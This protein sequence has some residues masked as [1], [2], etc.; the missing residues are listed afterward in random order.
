MLADINQNQY[1]DERNLAVAEGLGKGLASISKDQRMLDM[2]YDIARGTDPTGAFNR[3]EIM[4]KL[5]DL[6]N[7]P[8]SPMYKKSEQEL[9]KIASDLGYNVVKVV[10]DDKKEK[11][12]GGFK[13]VSG[14]K[15]TSRL[16]QLATNKNTG[17]KKSI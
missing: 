5:R 12:F 6:S 7:D 11:K 17:I 13:G 2:Q 14:K 1:M 15:Y 9:Q 3:Y 8:K 10:A 4:E 16:G